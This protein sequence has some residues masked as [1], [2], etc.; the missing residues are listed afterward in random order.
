RQARPPLGV[1]QSVLFFRGITDSFALCAQNDIQFNY[2]EYPYGAR[3]NFRL[4]VIAIDFTA[5][6]PLVIA[7]KQS[8]RGNPSLF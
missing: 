5:F 6:A 3:I 1:W 8:E 4:P 7:S 2:C